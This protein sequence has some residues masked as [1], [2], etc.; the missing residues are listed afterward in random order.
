[1]SIDLGVVAPALEPGLRIQRHHAAK[2]V[3][4]TTKRRVLGHLGEQARAGHEMRCSSGDGVRRRARH[5][6][7][8]DTS[9][10]ARSRA[11]IAM[12]PAAMAS[13][14]P[15]TRASQS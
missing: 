2:A 14:K 12:V 10:V 4:R 1:M 8:S 13:L 5:A 3:L 11:V 9:A 6:S 7:A 15:V